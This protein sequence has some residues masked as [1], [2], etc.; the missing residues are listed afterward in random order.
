MISPLGILFSL[1]NMVTL[2]AISTEGKSLLLKK[3]SDLK[4]LNLISLLGSVVCDSEQ[5]LGYL[6]F[7]P[8]MLALVR[9]QEG[10]AYLSLAYHLTP[11]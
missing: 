5:S 7:I 8:I 11:K 9:I 10:V 4:D 2:C 3:S 1:L 6:I